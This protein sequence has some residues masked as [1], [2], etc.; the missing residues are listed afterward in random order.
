MGGTDLVGGKRE[1]QVSRGRDRIAGREDT[2][3]GHIKNEFQCSGGQRN[4][5]RSH[6]DERR[7]HQVTTVKLRPDGLQEG[8][9][10][11]C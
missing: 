11:G 7:P 3:V 6:T 5:Y 1:N 9:G 10:R 4:V 2:V 8:S